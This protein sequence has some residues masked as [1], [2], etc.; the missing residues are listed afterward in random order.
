VSLV[1]CGY[2]SIF[3]LKVQQ[4]Q[5]VNAS[6][7]NTTAAT[8][9]NCSPVAYRG[10]TCKKGLQIQ[11]T[12][13]TGRG[14][15]KEVHIPQDINQEEMELQAHQLLTVELSFLQAS[16]ECEA[17]VRSF[18]CLY[19]FSL[20]DSGSGQVYQP[21]FTECVT[22]MTKTCAREWQIAINTQ[23]G[24]TLLSSCE[25]LPDDRAGPEIC[26]G[27]VQCHKISVLLHTVLANTNTIMH[28]RVA[29][30]SS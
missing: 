4:Q 26:D 29:S 10:E 27:T 17:A 12:C 21:S 2:V 24:Q 16:A 9:A 14:D 3:L 19:L 30:I 22:L 7:K 13:L 28:I 1:S 25:S 15:S 23:L 8:F 20:C 11:Q 18:L 5:Q 6:S